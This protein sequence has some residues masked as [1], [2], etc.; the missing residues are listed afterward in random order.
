METEVELLFW[1]NLQQKHKISCH[2][3]MSDVALGSPTNTNSCKPATFTHGSPKLFRCVWKLLY[4]TKRGDLQSFHCKRGMRLL[5]KL[6]YSHDSWIEYHIACA[7]MVCFCDRR[8]GKQEKACCRVRNASL[9]YFQ[10]PL[11][12]SFCLFHFNWVVIPMR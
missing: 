6:K 4:L 9:L 11:L 1:N 5:I 12:R 10:R 3:N 7:N 8:F 2:K